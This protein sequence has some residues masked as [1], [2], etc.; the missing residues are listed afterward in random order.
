MRA[1]PSQTVLEVL[2]N[3][4]ALLVVCALRLDSVRFG[5][6]GRR[7]EGVTPKMLTQTLRVLERDGLVQRTAYAVIP[8]RVEY[9]LTELGRELI[10]LLDA[11]LRWS[12]RH[13]PEILKAREHAR[14]RSAREAA[15]HAEGSDARA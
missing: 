1:C 10:G 15:E 13:A 9:K 2:A 14:A 3:K 12:E 11:I 7:I 5:E 8:P 4:W 6:L